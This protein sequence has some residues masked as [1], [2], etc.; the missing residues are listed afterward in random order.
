[1][2]AEDRLLTGDELD[3]IQLEVV[4][5]QREGWDNRND[6]LTPCL[7]EQDAKS[8]REFKKELVERMKALDIPIEP[9]SFSIGCCWACGE[10]VGTSGEVEIGVIIARQAMIRLVEE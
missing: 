6:V 1:M 5:G 2:K 7:I 8:I 4:K 9:H 3:K 10:D